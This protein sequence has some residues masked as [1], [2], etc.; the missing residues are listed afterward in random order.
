MI[1]P[2]RPDDQMMR[3]TTAQATFITHEFA[4]VAQRFRHYALSACGRTIISACIDIIEVIKWK[5]S[6][7]KAT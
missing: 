7:N 2:P 6:L 1:R 5:S 4:N 3:W